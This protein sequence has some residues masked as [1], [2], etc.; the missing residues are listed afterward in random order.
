MISHYNFDTLSITQ[1]R[2]IYM[3]I[4]N[5]GSSNELQVLRHLTVKFYFKPSWNHFPLSSPLS[6]VEFYTSKTAQTMAPTQH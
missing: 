2:G 3:Y 4:I 1:V 6:N 5:Q